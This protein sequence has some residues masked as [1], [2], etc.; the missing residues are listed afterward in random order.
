MAFI[1]EKLNQQKLE[2]DVKV[3]IVFVIEASKEMH[4]PFKDGKTRM[5]YVSLSINLFIDELKKQNQ[6]KFKFEISLVSFD[7]APK[8]VYNFISI[9][10]FIF[11]VPQIGDSPNLERG[12]FMGQYLTLNQ[13]AKYFFDDVVYT[14][15]WIIL[16]ADRELAKNPRLKYTQKEILESTNYNRLDFIWFVFDE[17]KNNEDEVKFSSRGNTLL[18]KDEV[19]NIVDEIINMAK[20]RFKEHIKSLKEENDDDSIYN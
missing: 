2:L 17:L 15:P 7:S 5:E 8:I 4:Q 20:K 12:V 14:T 3:P 11:N 1:K 13:N 10:Q 16:F 18:S 19:F 6:E 9:D